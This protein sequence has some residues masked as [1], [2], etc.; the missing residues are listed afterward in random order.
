MR[1]KTITAKPATAQKSKLTIAFQDFNGVF[2]AKIS[3]LKGR[4]TFAYGET[5]N[6]AQINALRNYRTKYQTV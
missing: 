4:E 5:K 1:N 3:N 2:L 6:L